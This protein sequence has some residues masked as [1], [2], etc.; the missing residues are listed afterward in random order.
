MVPFNVILLGCN[1]L[2]VAVSPMREAPSAKRN[3]AFIS[4][5]AT[6]LGSVTGL[7]SFGNRKMSHWTESVEYGD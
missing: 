5:I 1:T 6:I 7:R 2:V 3:A 4:L